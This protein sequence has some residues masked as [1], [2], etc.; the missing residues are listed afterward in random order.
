MK[1]CR[2]GERGPAGAD[3]A[4]TAAPAGSRAAD[5]EAAGGEQFRR[6]GSAR[7]RNVHA[8]GRGAGFV[9]GGERPQAAG[10]REL[11]TW[12]VPDTSRRGDIGMPPRP[13]WRGS[14]APAG[15]GDAGRSGSTRLL[16]S[17]MTATKMISPPSN[18]GK[19]TRSPN[20]RKRRGSTSKTGPGSHPSRLTVSSRLSL[21]QHSEPTRP[22]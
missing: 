9:W 7:A 13:A 12:R 3:V 4:A 5:R 21:L 17:R 14:G 19:A 15:L 10:G 1:R 6:L 20:G 11:G 22:Y 18:S 8:T 16:P 2:D